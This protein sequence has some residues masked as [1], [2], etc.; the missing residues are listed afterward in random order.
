[1]DF[2]DE[3]TNRG[4]FIAIL[5]LMAKGDP[6]LHKHLLTTKRN[7]IYTSKTIQNEVIH[8]YA[9]LVQEK[10]TKNIR[11][12]KLPFTIIADETTDRHSNQE[13]L[14]VSLRFVDLSS[15]SAPHIAENFIS[16]IYLERAN[17]STISQKILEVITAPSVS[18]DPH[19]IR[20]QAYD[21]AAVMS[22]NIAGVQAMIK[23]VSPLA[24]YTHC[25]S[26]CLNL[27][28]AA[29]CGIQEV[30]SMIALI[31]KC[32]SFCQIVLKDRN[33]LSSLLRSFCPILR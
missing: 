14:S 20:G 21:G 4:N 13:I 7:A 33:S 24:L 19:N 11:E 30:K 27:S 9:S 18:L 22:S 17:A 23:E 6:L 16:F 3:E 15:S 29:S 25:Y 26:H 5:Q 8:I 10:L 28:I 12:N 32:I 2:N 1:M 31:M